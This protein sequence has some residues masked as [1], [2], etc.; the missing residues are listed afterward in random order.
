MEIGMY[1][2]GCASVEGD[3]KEPWVVGFLKEVRRD[4]EGDHYVL[5]DLDGES[6]HESDIVA[7]RA[8][9]KEIGD[10]L[11]KNKKRLQEEGVS[12]WNYVI[13]PYGYLKDFIDEIA[14]R[15]TKMNCSDNKICNYTVSVSGITSC[16]RCVLLYRL[17]NGKFPVDAECCINI[18]FSPKMER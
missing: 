16:A 9:S 13:D 5:C 2:L 12:L 11:V 3:P 7:V 15:H 14:P 10:W 1:C 17:L 18:T 8:V 6:V 4:A